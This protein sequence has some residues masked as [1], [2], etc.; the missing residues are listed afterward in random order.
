MSATILAAALSACMLGSGNPETPYIT[1]RDNPQAR[2]KILLTPRP[3]PANRPVGVDRSAGGKL[4]HARYPVGSRTPIPEQ[5][6]PGP[7]PASYGAPAEMADRVIF[8]DVNHVPIAI[9]PW[10]TYGQDG[11]KE[12][13]LARNYWL[14]EN[15]YVQ[16]VRTHVNPRYHQQSEGMYSH[17][18]PTPRATIRLHD[19][20]LRRPSEMRVMTPVSGAPIER[21]SRPHAAAALHAPFR[22]I[23][24]TTAPLADAS[25]AD[26][27]ETD[28]R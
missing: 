15:G 2:D 24:D 1:Y 25:V 19:E 9:N 23:D 4:W 12:F 13:R 5:V 8:V 28:N 6:Y 21:V 16:K 27:S 11:F 10:R 18:L 20:P 22:V 3:Y 14:R 26:G 17:G 7:G